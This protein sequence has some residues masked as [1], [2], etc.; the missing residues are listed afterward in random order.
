MLLFERGGDRGL[1][2]AGNFH[3]FCFTWSNTNGDYQ[4]WI[5]GE[6]F[7]KGSGLEEGDMIKKG[8][9]VVVGQ[10]QGN[11]GGDFDPEQSWI[12]E[13]SGMNV[14]GVVLSEGDVVTEYHD[15]HVFSG[16]VVRWSQLYA[17]ESLHGD[18]SV[19]P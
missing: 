15:C 7:R 3:H 8:G 11:V 16:S 6:V 9:T 13:V 19:Y 5:D 10:D 18:V 2:S 12:G 17:S 14:W 1:L 4:F